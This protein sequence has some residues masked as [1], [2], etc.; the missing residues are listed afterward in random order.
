[1]IS[2]RRY[3]LD[4]V[5]VVL[6]YIFDY[7][8]Y[9]R[10]HCAPLASP[11]Q[12]N[13]SAAVAVVVVVVAAAAVVVVDDVVAAV[14]AAAV[15]VV[16]DIDDV[17]AAA[18]AAAVVVV[19]VVVDVVVV[20]VDAATYPFFNHRIVSIHSRVIQNSFYSATNSKLILMI[21]TTITNIP[22]QLQ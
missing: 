10:M 3:L 8:C 21:T 20:V 12:H 13:R 5:V 9:L 2:T 19:V 16:V 4:L 18:A 22:Q 17:V 6:K 1:M 14:A 11:A 7:Q 15:V